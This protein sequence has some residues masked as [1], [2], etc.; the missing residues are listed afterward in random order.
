VKHRWLDLLFT[1]P[2]VFLQFGFDFGGLLGTLEGYFAAILEFLIQ[3]IQ[4]IWQVLVAVANYLFAVLQFVW[5]FVTTLFADISKGFKWIWNTVIKG[6]LTKIVSVY[7]KVRDWLTKFLGPVLRWIQKI[8]KW[9]DWAFNKYVRPVLRLIGLLRQFLTIFRL[10]GAK[11]ATRLDRILAQIQND[12]LKGYTLLR[13][14]LN[15][16][17][18]YLQL[19][20]DPSAILRRNPLFAALIR[21]A[22][23]IRN[24]LLKVEQRDLTNAEADAQ[25]RDRARASVAGQK[26]IYSTYYSQGKIPPDMEEFQKQFKD[27]MDAL[28][29]GQ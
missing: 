25:D 12:I 26:N 16:V 2:F 29:A 20:V 18:T 27:E 15:K 3:V 23:E 17:T 6:A 4:F 5:K 8:R 28:L 13:A 24:M 9:V 10:L 7:V 19:I 11:W 21:S 1:A 14:E 22:P